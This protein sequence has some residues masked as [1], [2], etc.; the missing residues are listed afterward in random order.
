MRVEKIVVFVKTFDYYHHKLIFCNFFSCLVKLKF[1]SKFSRDFT[2]IIA[3]YTVLFEKLYTILRWNEPTRE[4]NTNLSFKL[5]KITRFLWS[6]KFS[7]TTVELTFTTQKAN[8]WSPWTGCSI[9]PWKYPFW[10][11][12][13]Q[14][15]SNLTLRVIRICRI[16]W[17]CSHFLF[18]TGNTFFE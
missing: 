8:A 14:K 3:L 7:K 15:L 6:L 12:L 5:F 9:F 18:S 17:W 10:L 16:P 1:T 2:R 4:E 11:N 13:V